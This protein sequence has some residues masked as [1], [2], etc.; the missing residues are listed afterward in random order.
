MSHGFTC[1]APYTPTHTSLFI[2]VYHNPANQHSFPTRR[3]SDLELN[4][5]N[6]WLITAGEAE[7]T[8]ASAIIIPSE[9]QQPVLVELVVDPDAR[10]EGLGRALVDATT[11]SVT[12]RGAE[13]QSTTA[14][15][16]GEHEAARALQARR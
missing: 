13:G 14:W 16:D 7:M 4:A 5:G 11:D 15:Y 2:S 10:G 12:Q 1:I 3:S 8:G 6:A 9:A